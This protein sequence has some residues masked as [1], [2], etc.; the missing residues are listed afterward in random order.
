MGFEL[1]QAPGEK[2]PDKPHF[3]LRVGEHGEEG[4]AIPP[5]ASL[6]IIEDAHDRMKWFPL[7]LRS[8]TI[9]RI[10]FK[11]GCGQRECTREYVYHASK[12]GHHPTQAR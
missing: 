7:I 2:P 11:C 3:V 6:N 4:I 10:V 1:K 5:G 12:S 9:K 8:V